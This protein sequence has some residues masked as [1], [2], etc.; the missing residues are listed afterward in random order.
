MASVYIHAGTILVYGALKH[1]YAMSHQVYLYR[2]MRVYMSAYVYYVF[3][4][5]CVCVHACICMCVRMY[6]YVCLCIHMCVSVC[7]SVLSNRYF[8]CDRCRQVSLYHWVS[9]IR[10]WLTG[11]C[12]KCVCMMPRI[13]I[14]TGVVSPNLKIMQSRQS[15]PQTNLIYLA[16]SQCSIRSWSIIPQFTQWPRSDFTVS[17]PWPIWLRIDPQNWP[18]SN[19]KT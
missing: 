3:M 6:A 4:C 12:M 16:Q 5:E 9:L 13:F 18:N 2:N 14:K 10:A 1:T 17:A 11:V 15:G 19:C 7:I 8:T